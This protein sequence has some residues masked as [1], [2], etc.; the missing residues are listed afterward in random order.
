[1]NTCHWLNAGE[2]VIISLLSFIFPLKWG[3]TVI[4]EDCLQTV[5]MKLLSSFIK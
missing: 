4:C 1:M 2:Y 3:L 5:H